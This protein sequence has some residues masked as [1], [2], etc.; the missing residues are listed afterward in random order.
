MVEVPGLGRGLL[1]VPER[2]TWQLF[3]PRGNEGG[4]VTC[5]HPHHVAHGGH[6][7]IACS[8]LKRLYQQI[9]LVAVQVGTGSK[10]SPH[11]LHQGDQLVEVCLQGEFDATDLGVELQLSLGF[12][13]VVNGPGGKKRGPKAHS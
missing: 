3:A 12:D 4:Q 9:E 2:V 13:A 7:G 10:A 11:R 6:A 1:A 8:Q 5:W